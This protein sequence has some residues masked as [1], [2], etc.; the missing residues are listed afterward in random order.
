MTW[1]E[2]TAM[3]SKISVR[4]D[5][6]EAYWNFNLFGSQQLTGQLRYTHA[7]HDYTPNMRCK[8][9]AAPIKEDITA[10]NGRFFLRYTY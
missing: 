5:A 4:G 1:A 10:K 2:D 9:W 8:G 3:G 6:Y 7:E